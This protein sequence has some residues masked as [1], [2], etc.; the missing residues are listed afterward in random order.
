MKFHNVEYLNS[1]ICNTTGMKAEHENTFDEDMATVNNDLCA[2]IIQLSHCWKHI[3]SRT[4]LSQS[5]TEHTSGI[6]LLHVS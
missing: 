3:L 2:L 4:F 1:S 5:R 6:Y